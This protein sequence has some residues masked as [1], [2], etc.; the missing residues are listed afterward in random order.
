M[1]AGFRFPQRNACC[2]LAIGMRFAIF[3]LLCL[4]ILSTSCG[5]RL[6]QYNV[7]FGLVDGA[8]RIVPVAGNQIPFR[9]GLLYGWRLDLD[10]FH[11]DV[12]LN[13]VLTLPSPA[14]WKFEDPGPTTA[15]PAKPENVRINS[16]GRVFRNE[17][18]ISK[19]LNHYT[20]KPNTM[21]ILP[22][23]PKGVHTLE[24][25]LDDELVETITYTIT[26]TPSV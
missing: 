22:N 17:M 10:R 11:Q 23:D 26:D 4:T 15:N 18:I 6:P 13:T 8:G 25:Y 5:K 3:S 14:D 21:K 12:K 2:R 9:V 19:D 1:K 16:R 20:T 7:Q 24:I